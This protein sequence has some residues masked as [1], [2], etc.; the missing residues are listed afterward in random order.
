MNRHRRRG[1]ALMICLVLIVFFATLSGIVIKTVLDDR[2]EART[3]SIRQQ[4]RFLLQDGLHRAETLRDADPDFSGDAVEIPSEH[5]AI[6]GVY[7]LTSVYD[8]DRK[9][10]RIDVKFQDR[11]GST[12]IARKFDP[13]DSK[14]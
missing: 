11:V 1:A 4:V 9:A 2:R 3:E 14:Q 10:F 13:T 6:P 5:P 12:I 8:G 7:T